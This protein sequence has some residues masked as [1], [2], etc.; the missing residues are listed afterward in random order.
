MQYCDGQSRVFCYRKNRISRETEQ[1]Y[2]ELAP[3]GLLQFVRSGR[4]SVTKSPM[5]ISHILKEFSK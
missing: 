1:L 5:Q 3:Y 4:I 2:K